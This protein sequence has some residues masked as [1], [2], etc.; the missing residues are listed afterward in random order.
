MLERYEKLLRE[1]VE[2]LQADSLLGGKAIATPPTESIFSLDASDSVESEVSEP[3][4]VQSGPLDG[5][6]D[7]HIHKDCNRAEDKD[8]YSRGSVKMSKYQAMRR[9]LQALQPSLA[10]ARHETTEPALHG[11]ACPDRRA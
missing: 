2:I 10:N 7:I 5:L 3:A 8:D 1:C 6:E 9:R 11:E 4:S